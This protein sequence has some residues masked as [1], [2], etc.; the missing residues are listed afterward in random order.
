MLFEG[1]SLK[2]DQF[3]Y[4]NWCGRPNSTAAYQDVIVATKP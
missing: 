1:V 4:G 3:I 2:P